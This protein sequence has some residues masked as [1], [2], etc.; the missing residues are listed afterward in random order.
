MVVTKKY[1]DW[2]SS[3]IKEVDPKLS[4]RNILQ[5]STSPPNEIAVTVLLNIEKY[6][7]ANASQLIS[8][9]AM[10]SSMIFML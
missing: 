6:Q 7:E 2:C 1:T 4:K 8:K 9:I 5:E 3:S 10:P